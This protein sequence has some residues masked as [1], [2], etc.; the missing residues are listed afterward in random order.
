MYRSIRNLNIPVGTCLS[1]E[2]D[3]KSSPGSREFDVLSLPCSGAFH[4]GGEFDPEV[5]KFCPFSP[6][7]CMHRKDF[8]LAA[9]AVFSDFEGNGLN[10]VKNWLK[11]TGMEKLYASF[12]GMYY[13][14]V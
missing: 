3:F 1:R 4:K 11:E 2:F 6:A 9:N 7:F 8:A 10:F 5:L 14:I 13:K 12:E